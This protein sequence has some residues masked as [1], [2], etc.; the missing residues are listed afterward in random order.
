MRPPC[1]LTCFPSPS[2][3]LSSSPKVVSLK[4]RAL[5]EHLLTECKHTNGDYDPRGSWEKSRFSEESLHPGLFH[6]DMGTIT[7]PHKAK[8]FT[9][10]DFRF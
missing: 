6:G 9:G 1:K 8:A 10:Q 3:E 7:V 4:T 5:I 2:N